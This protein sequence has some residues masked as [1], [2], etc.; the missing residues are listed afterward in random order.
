M[1]RLISGC[2]PDQESTMRKRQL[3][4]GWARARNGPFRKAG[5]RAI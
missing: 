1:T 3:L 4:D 2:A 5:Y